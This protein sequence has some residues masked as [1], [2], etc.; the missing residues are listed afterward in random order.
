[1]S[2]IVEHAAMALVAL[3]DA[4]HHIRMVS[5]LVGSS[6]NLDM[7]VFDLEKMDAEVLAAAKAAQGVPVAER[8]V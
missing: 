5:R 6:E 8:L 2:P 4:K 1:M 7:L 3:S